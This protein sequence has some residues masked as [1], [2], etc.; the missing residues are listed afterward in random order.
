MEN[1]IAVTKYN[2]EDYRVHG[3]MSV[4]WAKKTDTKLYAP[5][6]GSYTKG[7]SECMAE[8]E[9]KTDKSTIVF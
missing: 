9:R 3:K 8:L 7:I 6:D 4:I 5:Y 2:Y 1:Y